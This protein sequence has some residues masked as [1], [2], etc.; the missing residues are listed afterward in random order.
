MSKHPITIQLSRKC[1][2]YNVTRKFYIDYRKCSARTYNNSVPSHV[3]LMFPLTN[4]LI[5]IMISTKIMVVP[6]ALQE[7]C[8]GNL[9]NGKVFTKEHEAEQEIENLLMYGQ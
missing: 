4:I 1:A 3:I 7:P 5:S 6:I 2:V 8:S 9:H